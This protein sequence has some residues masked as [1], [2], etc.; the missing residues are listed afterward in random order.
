MQELIIEA[1]RSER[2]YW[3]DIWAFRELLYFLAWRDILVRYKQTVIGIGWA[4]V[5]P[6]LTMVVFTFLFGK[7]AKMPAAGT[8]PYSIMV[9]VALLPW[10]FFSNAFTDCSNSLISNSNLVSK[11]YFPRLI[12]PASSVI[13]CCVDLLIC[14]V[15]LAGMMAWYGYVPDI[16][17]L[18][19]PIFLA[20]GIAAAIGPGLWIAALAVKYRDMRYIVP[21]LVQFGTYVS[22]VGFSSQV[23]PHQWRLLYSINP[24][25]SVIDG[26]RWCLLRGEVPLYWPGL[27]V[28]ALVI[29][30]LCW[31]GVC[32]FR[33]VE[34]FFADII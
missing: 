11:I 20:A 7:L 14:C 27:A 23:I 18:G 17:V 16:R 8:A 12:M 19:L 28:S 2:Q 25:A 13:T 31:S 9:F 21:F 22:P 15:I 32:Y 1:G 4:V 5:R 33:K 26:F 30:G 24:M 10:Q 29:I 34:D 6:L 3:R